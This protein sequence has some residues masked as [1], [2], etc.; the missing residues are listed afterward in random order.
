MTRIIQILRVK[1]GTSFPLIVAVTLALVILLCGISEYFR[2][3]I[4]ASGVRDAVQSAVIATVNDNYDDV[5]HGVRE[6]YAGGYEPDASS[7]VESI[8]YGDIYGRLDETLGLQSQ[9]GY[10]VKY[11]GESVEY[12]LSGITVKIANVP[13]APAD[14]G[15]E[16][17]FIA[18]ATICLEV[19]VYFGGKTLPSMKIML[20][21]RAKYMPLF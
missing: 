2:L 16:Q 11:A 14:P 12:I 5:Y 7:W 21:V 1:D 3:M 18:D 4:I 17:S 19:P 20:K 15:K 8:D 10:H 6:G 9:S 13:F